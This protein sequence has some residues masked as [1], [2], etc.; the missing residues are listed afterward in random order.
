MIRWSGSADNIRAGGLH[1]SQ[2]KAEDMTAPRSAY[3]RK[4]ILDQR[5]PPDMSAE[6]R[7][8][9]DAGV[10]FA[11]LAKVPVAIARP[12]PKWSFAARSPTVAGSCLTASGERSGKQTPAS[13]FAFDR[14]STFD[15]AKI[16]VW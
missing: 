11:Q 14:F 3:R 8:Q 2:Q 15:D 1:S 12:D 5:A 4:I 9:T 13:E 16:Y 7:L 10:A 6:R